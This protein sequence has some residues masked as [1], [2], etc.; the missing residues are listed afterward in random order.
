MSTAAAVVR[1]TTDRS[2]P[3]EASPVFTAPIALA[4]GGTIRA[5]AFYG[6]GAKPGERPRGVSA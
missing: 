4:K 3:M 2:E 5:R 6:E 1:Y